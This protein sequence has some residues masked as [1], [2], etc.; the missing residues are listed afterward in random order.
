MVGGLVQQQDVGLLQQQPGQIDPGL[1]AAGEHGEFPLAHLRRD[2]QAVDHLLEVHLSLV[3]AAGGEAVHQGIVLGQDLP[4]GVRP[5]LGLQLRELPFQLLQSGKGRPEHLLHGVARRVLGNLGDQPH[6]L[7]RGENHLAGVVA[8]F[9]GENAE[10]RGLARAIA[11]HNAHALPGLDVE[12]QAV[13]YIVICV[14]GFD[15]IFY[16]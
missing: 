14:K 16:R 7:P 2:V 1:L 3:A 4:G 11:A 8:D 6:L 9:P 15:Q 12:G 10:Q 5:H 13:Q